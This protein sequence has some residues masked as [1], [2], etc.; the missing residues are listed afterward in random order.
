MA[1]MKDKNEGKNER[2]NEGQ[3]EGENE[4]KNKVNSLLSF[5][6][7]NILVSTYMHGPV[8]QISRPGK[9]EHLCF[10]RNN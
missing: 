3:S 4:K 5:S 2:K 1:K 6:G 8:L 7:C 9:M 10:P